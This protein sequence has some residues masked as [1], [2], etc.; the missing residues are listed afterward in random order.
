MHIPARVLAFLAIILLQCLP[1]LAQAEPGKPPTAA[2]WQRPVAVYTFTLYYDTPR[3]DAPEKL[4]RKLAADP[5][6]GFQIVNKPDLL[7]KDKRT[8]ALTSIVG[9]VDSAYKPPSL[10]SL[11]Y[12]GRGLSVAQ[13]QAL[14]TSAQVLTL[15]FAYPARDALPN[16]LRANNLVLRMATETRGLIWDDETR[17]IF[18]PEYWQQNRVATWEGQLPNAAH[19]ITIHAYNEKG[20]VRA[21]TLGMSK[22]A[23]PDL[24]INDAVW[25]LSGPLGNTLNAVAQRL[26]EGQRPERS[27]QYELNLANIKHSAMRKHVEDTVVGKASGRGNVQLVE[28]AQQSGDAD[29]ALLELRFNTSAGTDTTSRQTAFVTTVYGAQADDVI[30][31]KHDAALREAS[32]RARAK[33]PAL[34]AAFTA[35]LPPGETLSLKAPFATPTGG[36]EWMWVEVTQWQG[37]QISGMLRN[38]PLDAPTLKAGQIVNIKE[39]EV[40]DYIRRN[41]NGKSEGNETSEI[42]RKMQKG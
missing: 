17:E 40:F 29:N 30:R 41:P 24:V 21:I 39:D 28:S 5:Q 32:E 26:V 20:R 10:E 15:V 37:N 14:Q 16:L 19:H 13:A 2:T 7:A 9:N 6:F 38:Q 42:L 35:G 27:G 1:T 23:L 22:F 11:K 8:L 18:T 3:G 12:F 25:S 4:A 31:V 33:L 36:T 34:K